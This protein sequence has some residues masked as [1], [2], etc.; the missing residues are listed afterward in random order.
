VINANPIQN[1][2]YPIIVLF[3]ASGIASATLN[4][5]HGYS[6]AAEASG[7]V[8][9]VQYVSCVDLTVAFGAGN[10]PT[11][12]EYESWINTQSN[13][14]FNTTAQYLCNTNQWF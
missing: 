13:S 3:T 10:E 14:W 4:F 8:M 2:W 11:Q 12:T 1:Q 9:E 6:S 5:Q 7:K